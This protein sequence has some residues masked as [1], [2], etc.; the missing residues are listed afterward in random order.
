MPPNT[1]LSQAVSR[2]S[3][4][5]SSQEDSIWY[6]IDLLSILTVLP[7]NASANWLGY[8]SSKD[9]AAKADATPGLFPPIPAPAADA[10]H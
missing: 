9:S 4:S 5:V 10:G 2:I 1:S 3:L 8:P 6:W 7:P